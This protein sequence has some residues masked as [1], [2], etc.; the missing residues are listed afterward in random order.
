MSSRQESGRWHT[1]PVSPNEH[2]G[3]H[4]LTAACV[5]SVPRGCS[6]PAPCAS[7]QTAAGKRSSHPRA[8]PGTIS[9]S[10]AGAVGSCPLSP[11]LSA[12]APTSLHVSAPCGLRDKP[13]PPGSVPHCRLPRSGRWQS[14]LYGSPAPAGASA[15]Y[16]H[17]RS[18]LRAVAWFPHH[19]S[20]AGLPA[21]SGTA[22]IRWTPCPTRPCGPSDP[23]VV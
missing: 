10:P 11:S 19:R 8:S 7:G 5:C 12:C 21:A 18:L 22:C 6:A 17:A 4:L 3:T 13:S 23:P 1:V 14:P 15:G 20:A 9:G 16:V 2:A